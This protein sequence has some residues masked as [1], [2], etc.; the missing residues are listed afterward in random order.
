MIHAKC[1]KQKYFQAIVEN[2]KPWIKFSILISFFL[3]RNGINEITRL[4]FIL[5]CP[6]AVMNISIMIQNIW[7]YCDNVLPSAIFALFFRLICNLVFLCTFKSLIPSIVVDELVAIYKLTIFPFRLIFCFYLNFLFR[8]ISCSAKS[9]NHFSWIILILFPFVVNFLALHSHHL[10]SFVL[11]MVIPVRLWRI[12]RK[13]QD[14]EMARS[15][16]KAMRNRRWLCW[17]C[18]RR[19][20]RQ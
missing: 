8:Y 18:V 20:D 4:L 3:I 7:I 1:A 16:K 17:D 10:L 12:F 9:A 5:R 15:G 2:K 14:C 6:A 13:Y 11:Q 19:N